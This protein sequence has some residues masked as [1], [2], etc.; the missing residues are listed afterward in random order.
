M[1]QKQSAGLKVAE[2]GDP[3]LRQK[4]KNLSNAEI[5]S[6]KIQKLINKMQNFL[7]SKKMGVGLAAPQIGESLALAVL[8][9]RPLKHRQGT[10]EFDLVI[11]NPQIIKTYGSKTQQWEGCISGGSLKSGLFAKVPRYKKIEI[12]YKDENAKIHQRIFEGLPA[13]IIQH[14][15]DHLNGML[16]VDKVKDTKTFIT[17]NEYIKLAKKGNKEK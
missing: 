8:S 14:E 2:F 16:F 12:R 13:H 7:L 6:P 5:R 4:A 11:I 9:V 10:E 15:S 17:Y 3:I 1:V